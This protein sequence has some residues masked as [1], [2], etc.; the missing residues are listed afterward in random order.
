MYTVQQR[1]SPQEIIDADDPDLTVKERAGKLWET[2]NVREET[3]TSLADSVRL[4]A[5]LWAAA[6]KRGGGNKI[7]LPN[8]AF[9]EADMEKVYRRDRTFL[10]S[11][12]LAKMAET[13]E[14]EPH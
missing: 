2:K 6:W 14:F 3:I 11:L 7:P 12:S 1:L 5:G 13:G 10:P 9:A 8:A 4:L